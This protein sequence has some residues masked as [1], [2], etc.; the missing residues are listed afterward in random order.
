[1]EELYLSNADFKAY[2]DKYA[3]TYRISVKE[4]LGHYLVRE[5]AVYLTTD[6]EP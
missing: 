3:R 2:V 4:A 5:Y 1:M 6:S